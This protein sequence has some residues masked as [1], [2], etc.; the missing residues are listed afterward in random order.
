MTQNR[1][2]L[3]GQALR[4][5]RKTNVLLLI[6]PIK[7][8]KGR[9]PRAILGTSTQTFQYKIKSTVL[10]FEILPLNRKTRESKLL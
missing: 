5:I 7:I 8:Q 4:N 6:I 9:E 10:S 3:L 1:T 2:A